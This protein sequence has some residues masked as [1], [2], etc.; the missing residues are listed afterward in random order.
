M[1][2]NSTPAAFLLGGGSQ[3]VLKGCIREGGGNDT[4]ASKRNSPGEAGDDTAAPAP[5]PRPSVTTDGGG[6][7]PRPPLYSIKYDPAASPTSVGSGSGGSS[8]STAGDGGA[9]SLANRHA[10][11]PD[12]T[13]LIGLSKSGPADFG[14][15]DDWWLT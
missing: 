1:R 14:H 6:D 15:D 3:Y 7:T 12:P 13:L 8:S 9:S 5:E 10:P 11:P 4:M 2:H